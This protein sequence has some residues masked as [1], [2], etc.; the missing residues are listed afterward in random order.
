MMVP[1]ARFADILRTTEQ[2]TRQFVR[3]GV[4]RVRADFF[5]SVQIVAASMGAWLFAE[6]ILGHH[7]PISRRSLPS[8]PSAM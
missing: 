3:E 5:Q 4:H 1:M 8:Y 2:N 7:E 6:H